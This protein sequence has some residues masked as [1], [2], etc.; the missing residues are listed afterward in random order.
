MQEDRLGSVAVFLLGCLEGAEMVQA[1]E[2]SRRLPGE[3]HLA[4]GVLSTWAMV[5]CCCLGLP[6]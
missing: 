2:E 6:S 1:V 4:L 5:S 3:R